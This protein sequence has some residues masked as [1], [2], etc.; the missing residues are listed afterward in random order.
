[1]INEEN[2]EILNFL[3]SRNLNNKKK[4]KVK[5]VYHPDFISPMNPLFGMEYGQFVRGCHLGIF[6]SFYE[7]WGYTP[8]ECLASGVPAITSDLTGFGDYVLK[9]IPEHLEAGIYVVNRKGESFS[10]I[11]SQ[12]ANFLFSFVMKGRRDRINMRNRSEDVSEKFDW[13]TFANNY[14]KAYS[15]ALLQ[16]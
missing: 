1:M 11:A 16:E 14:Y 4:D 13:K 9:Y 12:L 8:L 10:S 15:R 7:P 3:K 5:I 6:P 2:D